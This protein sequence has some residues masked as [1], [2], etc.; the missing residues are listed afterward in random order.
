MSKQCCAVTDGLH[1]KCSHWCHAHF[2][3]PKLLWRRHGTVPETLKSSGHPGLR[4][5]Q[6]TSEEVRW[7][8]SH[9]HPPNGFPTHPAFHAPTAITRRRV[10][11][12]PCHA[13][14]SPGV[15]KR[16][17]LSPE[18]NSRRGEAWFVCARQLS[19]SRQVCIIDSRSCSVVLNDARACC[20]SRELQKSVC[21][22]Y[23][24]HI[25]SNSHSTCAYQINTNDLG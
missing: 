7:S 20:V 21:W 4:H 11:S 2:P 8:Q 12:S 18:K 3:A 1:G 9:P 17:S 23:T 22:Y 14:N 19:V 5:H 13:G 10:G 25:W 16:C 15:F 6:S 24:S